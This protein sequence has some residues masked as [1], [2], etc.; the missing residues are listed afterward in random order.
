MSNRV[1][2]SIIIPTRN[3][4][5]YCLWTVKQIMSLHLDG[6]EICI[7]DNS[8]SDSLRYRL[9][10]SCLGESVTYHFEPG[11][12]SFVDNFSHAVALASGE[13]ACMIGDDDGILPCIMDAVQYAREHSLDCLI[14]SLDVV[15][16]WPSNTPVAKDAERGLLEIVTPLCSTRRRIPSVDIRSLLQD[17]VQEYTSHSLPRLYH[18]LVRRS[19]LIELEEQTGRLFDGLTPDIYMAGSLCFFCKDVEEVAY[20]L[21]ISGICPRSGSA[22]SAS[23]RHTG[24][25]KDAPHFRGHDSYTWDA[26]I[27]AFYSVDT[28]WAETL[29]HALL[30]CSHP[31]L[32]SCFNL[33]LFEEI[34]IRKYPDYAGLIESHAREMGVSGKMAC[35]YL[36]Y[37]VRRFA[38]S[39][40]KKI[41]KKLAGC[42]YKRISDV[43]DIIKACDITIGILGQRG[44]NPFSK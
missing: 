6:L 29:M 1:N 34:C 19:T 27:P 21:T 11:V 26:L 8:D 38:Q 36:A 22:D 18:G 16:S 3:R 28:I 44:D 42:K 2:L 23:G 32:K 41:N 4:Q 24:D 20:P 10:E 12:L 30:N 13:Y 25:L 40:I 14:P 17:A 31:E 15:Y 5:E 7:Q 9:Q 35:A 39:A 33:P 37:R 43:H